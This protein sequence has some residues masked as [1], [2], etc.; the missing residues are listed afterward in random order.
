[1]Y[2]LLLGLKKLN[3]KHNYQ[4]Q[5][6][7]DYNILANGD[8]SI[9]HKIRPSV[10]T[11]FIGPCVE[12]RFGESN[13]Y[14]NYLHFIAASDWHR[15]FLMECLPEK[16]KGK[17]FDAWPIGI[18]T[19]FYKPKE[20]KIKYDCLFHLKHGRV[21][22]EW[23]I[24]EDLVKKFKLK[25]PRNR[26]KH[27]IN[28]QYTP[29]QMVDRCASCKFIITIGCSE[30]QGIG[31]ME[32]MS[33]NTPMFVLD[34]NSHYAFNAIQSNFPATTVPFWSKKCGIVLHEKDFTKE[35]RPAKAPSCNPK[36]IR[37]KSHYPKLGRTLEIE[38]I[39]E[40]FNLFLKSLKSY[41]PR[42]FILKKHTLE[43]SAKNLIK[44]FKKYE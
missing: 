20:K 44:I 12:S 25:T 43:K 33:N 7:G 37:K 17:T 32:M 26:N 11:S 6:E 42:E 18:D 31:K 29:K 34:C 4:Q 38:Y 16:S 2:N 40:Q 5:K 15:R 24:F 28:G 1:V 23:G 14:N 19:D 21:F 39:Y 3:I 9:F 13:Q 35:Y 22:D 27:L 8:S 41:N 10:K 30:T 36:S